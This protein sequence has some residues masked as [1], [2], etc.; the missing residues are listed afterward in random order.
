[1]PFRVSR[2]RR[3]CGNARIRDAL[4]LVQTMTTPTGTRRRSRSWGHVIGAPQITANFTALTRAILVRP[5]TLETPGVITSGF[6]A[7]WDADDNVT[8]MHEQRTVRSL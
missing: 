1:M 4:T 3:R 7:P 5:S 2:V 6:V 8:V